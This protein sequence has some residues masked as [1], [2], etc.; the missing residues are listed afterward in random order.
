MKNRSLVRIAAA[1]ATIACSAPALA[2]V[3]KQD[4]NG[5]LVAHIAQVQASP[6]EVWNR[7]VEPKEW[8]DKRFSWSGSA[9]G[10]SLNLRPGGCFCEL[11]ADKDLGDPAKAGQVEHMRVIHFDPQ[12]VLRMQGALG[13]LQS[14]ALQGTLTIAMAPTG[15][16]SSDPATTT[17]SF[18]YIVG[19]Y[20]R[21]PVEETAENTDMV[22][23]AQ[24]KSLLKPFAERT[25][26]EEPEDKWKL[27]LES[28][29][30][31]DPP[32]DDGSDA[33]DNGSEIPTE[34]T[35]KPGELGR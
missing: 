7:L 28:L 4:A 19:G 2:E 17:V 30:D 24:F 1:S 32:A 20:M 10:F 18:N 21:F 5:F 8:W 11:I 33:G 6:D 16:D 14:E 13:P 15:D 12:R 34:L 23:G 3:K 31:G 29:T 25:K 26:K 22:I 9:E 27:D 35:V